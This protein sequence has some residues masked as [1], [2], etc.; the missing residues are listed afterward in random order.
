MG[1]SG[2]PKRFP[3]RSSTLSKDGAKLEPKRTPKWGQNQAFFGGP[4]SYKT[5]WIPCVPVRNGPPKGPQFSTKLAQMDQNGNWMGPNGTKNVPKGS[6]TVFKRR[7]KRN[8]KGERCIDFCTERRCRAAI[9]FQFYFSF[10][11]ICCCVSICWFRVS[12]CCAVLPFQLAVLIFRFNVLCWF[13]LSTCC[14]TF[15]LRD[16]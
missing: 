13:S 6:Q 10:V 7:Q 3:K 4:E 12:T 16:N 14:V 1:G 5:I 9:P 2:W 11:L 8:P 15:P